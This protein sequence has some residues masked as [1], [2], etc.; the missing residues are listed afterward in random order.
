MVRRLNSA[1]HEASNGTMRMKSKT[2]LLA[3]FCA[4]SA[5]TARGDSLTE[6]VQRSLKE[7]GFYYGEPT[8]QKDADTAAA[9]RRYQI[10]NGLK[11]NGEVTAETL[12]SLGIKGAV[13]VLAPTPAPHVLRL[14]PPPVATPPP[15]PPPQMRAVPSTNLFARSPYETATPDVQEQVLMRAQT[16]LAKQGYYRGL[17]DGEFGPQ[18]E[19]A[20]RSFQM[21]F[22][23]EQTGRLDRATLGVLGLLPGQRAPGVTAPR[24]FGERPSYY[25]PRGE[26]VYIP[27]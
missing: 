19:F 18:M 10:R 23:L 17:V 20:L 5:V 2:I 13:P 24:R 11:I 4:L 21:R 22:S 15:S 12:K 26:P 27:R 8:G 14:A 6:S 7:Q 16:Q 25:T 9:I 1:A 3:V